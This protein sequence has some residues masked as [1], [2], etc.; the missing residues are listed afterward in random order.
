MNQRDRLIQTLQ[1]EGTDRLP[2][3]DSGYTCLDA[4]HEQGL[5][6]TVDTEEQVEKYFGLDRG[7]SLCLLT[8]HDS[9][10]ITPPAGRH[11]PHL[12]A[13]MGE[14]P[15]EVTFFTA[16]SPG[17]NVVPLKTPVDL[18][19]VAAK[20]RGNDQRRLVAEWAHRLEAL[21][22]EEAAV[23]IYLWGFFT[24]QLELLGSDALART[25]LKNPAMIHRINL[26]HLQF[27]RELLEMVRARTSIDFAVIGETFGSARVQLTPNLY[28]EFMKRY[29]TE[30]ISAIRGKNVE[31]IALSGAGLACGLLEPLRQAGINACLP[32]A[33]AA[34]DEPLALREKNPPLALYGGI[35]Y[36]AVLAGRDAINAELRRIRPLVKAGGYIP[37]LDNAL[38][39]E[40]PL[41]NY[42]YYLAQK[43]AMFFEDQNPRRF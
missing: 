33:V 19:A 32:C 7:F 41:A 10:A 43:W 3:M 8:D 12:A 11:S 40:T 21:Q 6:P 27:C 13:L 31:T 24:C 29:Y 15:R 18:E 23:G 5:P 34:G 36:R 37:A 25:Y 22:R 2:Y 16:R 26:H 28:K 1:F 39:P 14:I 42:E 30:L 35:D 17:A 20:R 38:P 4:W 9:M